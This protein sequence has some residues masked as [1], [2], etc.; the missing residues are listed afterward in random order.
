MPS[1]ISIKKGFDHMLRS[2]CY[3]YSER[4]QAMLAGE[5]VEFTSHE[6]F[7]YVSRMDTSKMNI[8]YLCDQYISVHLEESD[9]E[10]VF[11]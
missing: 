2:D 1:H 10:R 3:T 9:W 7:N 6:F 4:L 8:K 11:N 5:R